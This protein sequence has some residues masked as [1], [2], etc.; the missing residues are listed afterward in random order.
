MINLV[1]QIVAETKCEVVLSSVWR[2]DGLNTVQGLLDING[3][4]FKLSDE[5]PKLH[6]TRGEEIR[7][8]MELHGVSDN[9]IVILDDG[10]DMGDL[11]PR[12]VKTTWQCGLQKEHANKVIEMLK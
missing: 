7:A 8:W 11:M 1:N 2:Y 3:A 9:D 4:S 10:A 6:K 5:T 12:L